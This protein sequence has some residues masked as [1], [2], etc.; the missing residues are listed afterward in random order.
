MV[1][2][3]GHCI[4]E[5]TIDYGRH[6][7]LSRDPMAFPDPEVFNPQRWLD[8]E[9]CLKDNIKFIVYGFGR[10]VCPGMHLA[11]QS[12]YIAIAFLLWSFRIAQRPDSPIDTRLQ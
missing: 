9:G 10:R 1:P 7:I 12:L 2:E 11:N 5:G 6:W 3:Q 8:S 4:P